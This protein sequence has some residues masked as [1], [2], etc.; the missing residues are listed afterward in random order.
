MQNAVKSS[1]RAKDSWLWILLAGQLLFAFLTRWEISISDVYQGK[2]LQHCQQHGLRVKYADGVLFSD[3]TFVFSH[4]E[5]FLGEIREPV[6][7]AEQVAIELRLWSFLKGSFDIRSVKVCNA[8]FTLPSLYSE[9]GN[10]ESLVS[11]L[12]GKVSFTHSGVRLDSLLAKL[13]N[14]EVSLTEPTLLNFSKPQSDI[15][16]HNWL[17]QIRPYLTYRPYLRHLETP[18]LVFSNEKAIVAALFGKGA[19][20]EGVDATDISISI[21]KERV[22]GAG[23]A[24]SFRGEPLAKHF[25]VELPLARPESIDSVTVFGQSVSLRGATIP[26][27]KGSVTGLLSDTLSAQAMLSFEEDCYVTGHYHKPSQ[28]G[29]CHLNGSFDDGIYPLLNEGLQYFFERTS[30]LGRAPSIAATLDFQAAEIKTATFAIEARQFCLPFLPAADLQARG[31]FNDDVLALS[32][33]RMAVGKSNV[34]GAYVEDGGNSGRY[35]FMLEGTLEPDHLNELLP[36]WWSETFCDFTI[37]QEAPFVD[38]DLQGNWDEE[39]IYFMSGRIFGKKCSFRDMPLDAFSGQFGYDKTYFFKNVWAESTGTQGT[40]NAELAYED[41]LEYLKFDVQSQ[42]PFEALVG[43]FRQDALTEWT[44]PLEFPLAPEIEAY[45]TLFDDPERDDFQVTLTTHDG[46]SYWGVPFKKLLFTAHKKG[47]QLELE[48]IESSLANGSI[49]GHM[50]ADF[51]NKTLSFDTQADQLE[52][53]LLFTN[54]PLLKPFY[55]NEYTSGA[56]PYAGKL[57]LKLH[58]SGNWEHMQSFDVHG[59]AKLKDANL[60]RIH[61]LGALSRI[62]QGTPLNFSSLEFSKAK[63]HF[64]LKDGILSTDDIMLN[65]RLARL[66]GSGSMDLDKQTLDAS[67]RMFFFQGVKLPIV[68]QILWFLRPISSGFEA[69]L[70]GTFREPHW[71]LSFNPF[72]F[73]K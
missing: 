27:L 62:M 24:L 64:A 59:Y 11:R 42:W 6:I 70:S 44:M 28:R 7:T 60:G 38:L 56:N 1:F 69:K 71:A 48:K 66:E 73:L 37:G 14:L 13:D 57:S 17:Q 35:R 51:L 46:G 54:I 72:G 58:G 53:D 52:N 61:L 32:S 3:G 21:E 45:G 15:N 40:V 30:H 50:T 18:F 22:V 2:L 16:L 23:H 67:V 9:T 68:K 55:I 8:K 25:I 20:F 4:V 36:D 65:S 19:H 41:A 10:A 47:H 34:R 33:L 43:V 12:F 63:G 5:I 29:Q 26:M 31:F 49:Q 39:K